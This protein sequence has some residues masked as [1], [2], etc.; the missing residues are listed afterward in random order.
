MSVITKIPRS[1]KPNASA[2]LF[3]VGNTGSYYVIPAANKNAFDLRLVSPA[4]SGDTRGRYMDL[5]LTGAGGG[6]AIRARAIAGAMGVANGGTV[7]GIHTT[8]QVAA[9]SSVSGAGNAIRA[10]LEAAAASRTL[11]G[12]CAALQLDSNIGANNTVPGSYSL[13]RV[14][15]SG[16]VDVPLFMEVVDDQCLKGSAA[17][18]AAADALTVKLPDGSTKYIS[19]IAAS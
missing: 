14:T 2:L 17:T 1:I 11:A 16:S 18:G 19:L 8:L 3:G 7:N 6:E 15:K 9:S 13:I 4:A 10:T 5:K 12:T